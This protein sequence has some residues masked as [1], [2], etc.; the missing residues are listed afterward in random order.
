MSVAAFL[1]LLPQKLE[2]RETHNKALLELIFG[3]KIDKTNLQEI[4]NQFESMMLSL[5]KKMISI[6]ENLA[7]SGQKYRVQ[8]Y[9]RSGQK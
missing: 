4:K 5:E 9:N 8:R 1:K 2:V 6:V 3:E 7:I